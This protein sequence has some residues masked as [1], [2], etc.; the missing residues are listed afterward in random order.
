MTFYLAKIKAEDSE[1]G[2]YHA[3]LDHC[4]WHTS[5]SPPLDDAQC[6]QLVDVYS[7][8]EDWETWRPGVQM[9][10]RIDVEILAVV[11][12]WQFANEDAF[13][14]DFLASTPKSDDET[15]TKSDGVRTASRR[16]APAS[17]DRTSS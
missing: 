17:R 9:I 1:K 15:S 12:L 8:C 14:E 4:S 5:V 3:L 13:I 10:A 6:M 11:G 2:Y 16:E 7:E